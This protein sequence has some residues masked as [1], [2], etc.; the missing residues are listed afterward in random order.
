MDDLINEVRA[1]GGKASSTVLSDPIPSN[2]VSWVDGSSY[3]YTTDSN[4][5]G[6]TGTTD[7]VVSS[8]SGRRAFFDHFGFLHLKG[9]CTEAE[10]DAMLARMGQLVDSWDPSEGQTFRTDAKQEE[11][12]GSSDYFL[13]SANRTHF[14]TEPDARDAD[15]GALIVE[16]ACSLNKVGHGIHVTDDIFRD[17]C[18]SARMTDLVRSLGWQR[19]VVPQSMYIF[20]QP[21]IGGQVTAHQDSTFL[22]TEPRQ[23]CL[24]LWLAL[25][26]AT[27][28]NGCL[29]VRPFS[30]REPVRRRFRRNPK[31]FVHGDKAAP[32]MIFDD[33]Q[34]DWKTAVPWEGGLPGDF[35]NDND[36]CAKAEKKDATSHRPCEGL[37]EQRFIPVECGKGDLVVFPGTLD[38]LSLANR[39]EKSRHT[40]QLHLVEG[41]AAGVTWSDSNWLQ[42]PAGEKFLELPN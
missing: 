18:F 19:P 7:E 23:T 26:P 34:A 40:F 37:F 13:D 29:W 15:T 12:Q 5:N 41:P 36:G 20:K 16:K 1:E 38:H 22:Y 6:A 14:F 10:C 8:A 35:F 17:Y 25:E 32:Q 2:L 31:H 27:L 24:G 3:E 30:H 11:A 21:R 42:Y 39:S 33:E 4:G 9:F 28:R